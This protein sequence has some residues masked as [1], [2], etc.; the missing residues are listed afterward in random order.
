VE[1]RDVYLVCGRGKELGGGGRR[2]RE[3]KVKGA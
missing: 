2:D 1:V 3:G